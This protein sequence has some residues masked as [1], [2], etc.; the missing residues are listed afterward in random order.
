MNEP[1]VVAIYVADQEKAPVHAV[2]EALAEAGLGLRGDRYHTKNAGRSARDAKPDSEV[3]LIE[4]EAIEAAQRDYNLA[5]KPGES[6]RN[7]VTRGVALNH[8][9]G[10]EFRVGAAWL[11]GMRLCEPCQYL[12]RLTREG[13]I[14]S[15]I[16]R[17]GLRA[18]VVAGGIIRVGDSIHVE[19]GA[20]RGV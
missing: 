12:E 3:T 9:V 16:H 18:R 15:L 20:E 19:Q 4:I 11:L 1:S 14:R 2:A 13:M 7:I 5:L 6:R 10:R 17:G 8:L